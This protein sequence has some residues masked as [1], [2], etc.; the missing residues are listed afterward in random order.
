MVEIFNYIIEW[1]RYRLVNFLYA[2]SP[3][4]KAQPLNQRLPFGDRHLEAFTTNGGIDS[5]C[6]CLDPG[7]REKQRRSI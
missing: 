7:I 4:T 1:M 2:A 6:T 5:T 3:E